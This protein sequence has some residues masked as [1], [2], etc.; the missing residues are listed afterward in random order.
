[1]MGCQVEKERRIKYIFVIVS[2]FQLANIPLQG[3]GVYLKP[4]LNV[5]FLPE[6][7][8]PTPIISRAT[9]STPGPCE[10]PVNLSIQTLPNLFLFAVVEKQKRQ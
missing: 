6:D 10:T 9:N 1:M 4:N 3:T 8:L 5:Q 7:H 2:I